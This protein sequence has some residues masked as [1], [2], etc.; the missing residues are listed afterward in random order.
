MTQAR[1]FTLIEMMIVLAIIAIII[2][3]AMPSPDPTVARRQVVESLE[4]IE[5]YKELVE[6]YHKSTHQFLKD[7]KT[8]GIPPADKLLGNYVTSIHLEKGAFHLHFGNKA[9]VAIKDK[10]ISVRPIVVKGSPQ[11][12][13]SWVC[14]NS[15]AP[16]GMVA[17]G[18]NKTNLELKDLPL[19]CRI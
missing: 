13:I 8:A 7:N 16:E 10:I 11:S 14:G 15:A 6:F 5:D 3:M 12:P 18:D 2:F 4:L 1:G 17:V 19:N 9:H